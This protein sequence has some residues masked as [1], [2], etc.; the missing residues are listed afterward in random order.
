[1]LDKELNWSKVVLIVRWCVHRSDKVVEFW[2]IIR[3]CGT[4]KP[5]KPACPEQ[6]KESGLA[7]NTLS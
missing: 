6:Q 5:N 3:V 4:K 1:M 2:I 7:K